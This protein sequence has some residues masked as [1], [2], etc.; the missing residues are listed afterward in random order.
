MRN[1]LYELHFMGSLHQLVQLEL[2][3]KQR[4][5]YKTEWNICPR[6]ALSCVMMT[7]EIVDN[8]HCS[9]IPWL[10]RIWDDSQMYWLRTHFWLCQAAAQTPIRA[11]PCRLLEEIDEPT[12][13]PLLLLTLMRCVLSGIT[14]FKAADGGAAEYSPV[15]SA[16]VLNADLN[17]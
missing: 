12:R 8:C 1:A 5:R 11:Q 9:L 14:A 15:E 2:N 13:R 4:K 17:E 6:M 3:Q 7:L 16:L 10:V